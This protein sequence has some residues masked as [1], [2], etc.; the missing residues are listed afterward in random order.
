MKKSIILAAALVLT[1]F[2]LSFVP[3]RTKANIT[4][5]GVDAG[6]KLEVSK[7]GGATWYN[8][9]ADSNP[10]NQTLT[11]KPG[12]TLTFR[13]KVWNEGVNT[14]VNLTLSGIIDHPEYFDMTGA[15]YDDDEDRDLV[16]YAGTIGENIITLSE[17][18]YNS[19][20]ENFHY[21][22]GT[23]Q[24]TLKN[25]VPDQTV[26]TGTF[27]IKNI[28]VIVYN[29]PGFNVVPKTL[30]QFSGQAVSTVRILADNKLPQTGVNL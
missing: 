12:D 5:G 18:H 27:E 8:Y 24:A 15:F 14:A 11:A 26:I 4:G 10:G 19:A 3:F 20:N 21:E 23:F 28:S 7:D 17:I 9:T 2:C 6:A 25:D 22:G 1:V 13:G 29:Q 16:P 30:A